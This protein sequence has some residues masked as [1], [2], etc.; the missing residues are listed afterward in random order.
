VLHVGNW[1]AEMLVFLPYWCA[2]LPK[3]MANMS[4]VLRMM[5]PSESSREIEGQAIPT[6]SEC[7]QNRPA[8]DKVSSRLYDM[9]YY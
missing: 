4:T 7:V 8:V 2:G 5:L 6:K 3:L 1:F 9:C